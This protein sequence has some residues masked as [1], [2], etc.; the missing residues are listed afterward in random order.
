MKVARLGFNTQCEWVLFCHTLM[1]E[2]ANYNHD[3]N[4]GTTTLKTDTLASI[5][6]S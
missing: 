2:L 6:L 5:L 4:N 3:I 1:G